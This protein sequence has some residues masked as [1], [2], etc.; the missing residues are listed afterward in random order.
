MDRAKRII[1]YEEA[2][3]GPVRGEGVT[4][5]FLDS[6]IAPHP[7]LVDKTIAFR[8]FVHNRMS[9]YDDS[10][11]GT[12]VCGIALGTGISSKGRYAG[13]APQARAVVGKVLDAEGN[14]NSQAM[15][16]GIDW[17]IELKQKIPIHILNIS[18]G[19]KSDYHTKNE[20]MMINAVE[21]AWDAGLVV[22]CA[23]GNNGP[24][25][26][27]LSPMAMSRI[28]ITVGCHDLG[29][30]AKNGYRCEDC[31][32]RG[33]SRYDIKKPDIVAPG[34]DI[35][36]CNFRF[37]RYHKNGRNAYITKSGTSMS[38]PMVSGAAAL[39][40]SSGQ[41]LDS[42]QIKRKIMYSASDLQEKWSKQGWGML[43]IKNLMNKS[44]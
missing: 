29:Y 38:T 27:S 25:P 15:L 40:L 1:Q 39:L 24:A 23:S 10:G 4:I 9:V 26:M 20:Q 43:N 12:H 33:P 32:G 31:S 28:V 7:D 3:L 11:H 13:I 41:K 18:V 34:T 6:G 22:V 37:V 5:A 42:E 8:D 2:A 19:V 44:Y 35:M 17:I 16:E 14:G 21:K 36:S 30:R